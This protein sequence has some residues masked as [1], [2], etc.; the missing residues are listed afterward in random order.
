MF[1]RFREWFGPWH[2]S[3]GLEEI[4]AEVADGRLAQD[5][6]ARRI[7]R[8]A[9]KPYVPAWV[10]GFIRLIGATGLLLGAALACYRIGDAR[11]R[12]TYRTNC[13]REKFGKKGNGMRRPNRRTSSN[14][15]GQ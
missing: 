15:W 14:E 2:S 6:A 7:R 4:L 11:K 3:A 8:L 5:D 10:R 13:M 9:S 12:G 1:R